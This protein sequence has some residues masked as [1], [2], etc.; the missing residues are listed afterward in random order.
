MNNDISEKDQHY[1]LIFER[2]RVRSLFCNPL[3]M[4]SDRLNSTIS[5]NR[6]IRIHWLMLCNSTLLR[7]YPKISKLVESDVKDRRIVRIWRS[8]KKQERH[9]EDTCSDI[10]SWLS[11]T[12]PRLT[13]F[14]EN[15]IVEECS[16]SSSIPIFSSLWGAVVLIVRLLV[17]LRI[18]K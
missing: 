7:T 18:N 3:N 11:R 10:F 1:S 6:Q 9:S 16:M 17:N 14:F 8:W 13:T 5:L 4:K 12:T 15:W 2:W